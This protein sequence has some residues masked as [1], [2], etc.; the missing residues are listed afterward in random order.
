MSSWQ[1]PSLGAAADISQLANQHYPVASGPVPDAEAVLDGSKALAY[2]ASW[3]ETEPL[4]E[5]AKDAEKERIGS[6]ACCES[7]GP[8]CTQGATLQSQHEAVALG[9][10]P[11]ARGLTGNYT[12]STDPSSVAR[13]MRLG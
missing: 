13:T 11:D 8:L 10:V 9:P 3:R 6:S 4:A 7:I 5:I 12:K 2:S 1:A